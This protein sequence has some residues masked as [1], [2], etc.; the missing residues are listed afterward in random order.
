MS[1]SYRRLH[2][3]ITCSGE[4]RGEH[5]DKKRSSRK[6]RRSNNSKVGGLRSAPDLDESE[7]FQ[8]KT[9]KSVQ[10]WTF[11]GECKTI[12]DPAHPG[13]FHVKKISKKKI[14]MIK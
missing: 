4:Q 9:R 1:Q 8:F 6:I 14:R 12:V 3:K 10:R 13:N 11:R 7:D 5:D 2:C